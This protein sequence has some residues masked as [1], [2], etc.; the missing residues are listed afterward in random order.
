MNGI[1][2]TV[3]AA[4]RLGGVIYKLCE[5]FHIVLDFCEY[6]FLDIIRFLDKVTKEGQV[7]T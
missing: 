6:I 4:V 2:Q 7:A 3:A 1:S 5:Q